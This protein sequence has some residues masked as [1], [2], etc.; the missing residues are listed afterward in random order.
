MHSAVCQG[1]AGPLDGIFGRGRF[2]K[3]RSLNLP[4]IFRVH[5]GIKRGMGV[6]HI[7]CKESDQFYIFHRIT[8]SIALSVVQ[9]ARVMLAKV[10]I[11]NWRL[12]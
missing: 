9:T 11:L 3:C 12:G 6:G 5:K 8:I 4:P 1:D 10:Q 2:Q 7:E